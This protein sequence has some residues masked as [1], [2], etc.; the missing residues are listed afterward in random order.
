MESRISKSFQ[1]KYHPVALIW[2]DQKPENA[3]QFKEKINP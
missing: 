1:L 3:M 2:S